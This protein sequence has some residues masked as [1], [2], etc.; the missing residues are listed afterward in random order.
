[1]PSFDEDGNLNY[2]V[3]RSID[4]D[5]KMKYVNAKVPKKTVIFNGINIDWKSELTL[6]EGP[7]DLVKCNDN[8]TCLL[9]SSLGESYALFEN[10]VR[11]GTPVLL[12][13][14]PDAAGKAQEIAKRLA[15]YGIDVRVLDVA[16]FD[17]VGEMSRDDFVI[18][19]KNAKR[20]SHNDRLFHMIKSLKSGSII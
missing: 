17:D 9:G 1:M 3:G 13:M 16:P 4:D 5:T 6:V 15:Y 10:I 14:D 8:A 18:A 11:N 20:W 2:Y 19:K 12:A 7:M